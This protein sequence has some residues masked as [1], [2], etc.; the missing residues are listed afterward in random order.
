MKMSGRSGYLTQL[1]F[2]LMFIALIAILSF[3]LRSISKQNQAP[4]CHCFAVA[5]LLADYKKGLFAK[6]S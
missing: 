3:L 1:H 6:K 4:D 5:E 2:S